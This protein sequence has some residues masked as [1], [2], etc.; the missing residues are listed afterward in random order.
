MGWAGWVV[1]QHTRPF[2]VLE[3][4]MDPAPNTVRVAVGFETM[5]TAAVLCL[6][7]STAQS[8][9]RSYLQ[10]H[11]SISTLCLW[12]VTNSF[13]HTHEPAA[14]TIVLAVNLSLDVSMRQIWRS[15]HQT[16]RCTAQCVRI[17]APNPSASCL[18]EAGINQGS[19][20]TSPAAQESATVTPQRCNNRI[21]HVH[22]E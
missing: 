14:F 11:S 16:S 4:W 20:I 13:T 7:T 3:F 10:K 9:H 1:S 17:F 2:D 19:T 8:R 18:Y 12:T 21:I 22:L 5:T 6:H 15:E